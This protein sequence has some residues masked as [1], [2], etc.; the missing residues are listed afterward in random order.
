MRGSTFVF[1]G[2]NFSIEWAAISSASLDE[3]SIRFK[4]PRTARGCG[5]MASGGLEGSR[6]AVRSRTRVLH[7]NR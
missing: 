4:Y 5:G 6:V 2:S 1:L 3:S 7:A